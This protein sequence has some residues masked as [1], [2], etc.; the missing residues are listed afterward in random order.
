[1]VER[2]LATEKQKMKCCNTEY[3]APVQSSQAFIYGGIL[4]AGFV[5]Y[6]LVIF[7]SSP[8]R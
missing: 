1:Y 5:V 3:R 7:F 6:F 8:E 4:I 2:V